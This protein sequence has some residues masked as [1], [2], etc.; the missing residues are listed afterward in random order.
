MRLK[1]KMYW[2]S[3]TC[4]CRLGTVMSF[5]WHFRQAKRIRGDSRKGADGAK[6]FE[7]VR[8]SDRGRSYAPR[9]W[10]GSRCLQYVVLDKTT[11]HPHWRCS[12]CRG[13]LWPLLTAIVGWV[14]LLASCTE[15]Q[16]PL[17][18]DQR[19]SD[20]PELSEWFTG[21]DLASG[22]WQVKMPV[23]IT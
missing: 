23:K 1:I 17:V 12:T 19:R 4:A 16:F 10:S 15:V 18:Q 9:W 22:Y 11:L 8:R 6:C 14:V 2:G 21:L 7:F 5:K 13:T 3:F 20:Q